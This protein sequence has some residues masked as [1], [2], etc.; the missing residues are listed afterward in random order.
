M[1]DVFDK[2]HQF[3]RVE[4][5]KAMNNIFPYYHAI[6]EN[7]GPVI[8]IF[9]KDVVMAG[10]NNYLGLSKHPEVVAA[11]HKAIDDFGTSAS[12]SRFLNGTLVLHE[13]LEEE[14]ADF[15]GMESC[16]LFT[17]G[18]LANQGILSTL[19][20]KGEYLI[21]DKDNHA[22]IVVGTLIAKAMAAEVKRYKNNDM[23]S[24]EKVLKGLP[25]DA[26]KLIVSDGVFSMSGLVVD[27]PELVRL[28]K[29]YKAR[30]MIDEAHSVGVLGQGGLG[31]CDHF[32]LQ[33]GRDV[34]LVMGTFSKSF[35]SL[36]GFVAGKK[37]VIE[38][39]KYMSQAVIFSASMTPANVAAVSA[40]LKIIRREP[41]RIERLR[42]IG[43][44]MRN[45]FKQ[46]GLTI[47]DGITPIVP[48]IVGDDIKTFQ[49][50]R[51]LLDEGVF[52]NA[53]VSPAAPQGQQLIRTSYMATHENH[54]LDKIIE[55]FAKVGKEFDVVH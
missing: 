35:A 14:L 36:G 17:T 31:I 20:G 39:I 9:G 32:G 25:H 40:A 49:V 37:K 43:D 21:S 30:L 6:E 22:S 23:A 4:K 46:A 52:A 3:E 16:Q 42:W 5:I 8:R 1:T 13:A 33:N 28:A 18:F 7:R 53:V 10:S 54:H 50:W 24:L 55:T 19:V 27:L 41:E 45:G 29:T 48:V 38:Y 2:C 44:Y 47:I 34:D 12:G 26:P 15:L 11:A 51:R